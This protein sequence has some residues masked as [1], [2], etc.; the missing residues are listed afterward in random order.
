MSRIEIEKSDLG[1]KRGMLPLRAT[2][3]VLTEGEDTMSPDQPRQTLA[4]WCL[5]YPTL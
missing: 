5:Q 4:A 1:N 2:S 3:P